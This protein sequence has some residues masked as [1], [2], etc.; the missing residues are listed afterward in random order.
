LCT[1][2]FINDNDRWQTSPDGRFLLLTPSGKNQD[3]PIRVIV[4]WPGAK[5]GPESR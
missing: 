5:S 4:N 1:A 3:S 2:N